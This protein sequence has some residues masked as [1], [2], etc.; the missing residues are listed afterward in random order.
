MYKLTPE[1]NN[2]EPIPGIP[3]RD[4]S[5]EEYA[6]VS[7]EYDAR[8]PDQPGSL[9]RWFHHVKDKPAEAGKEA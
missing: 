8:F 3:W 6:E 7:A 5:D 2:W 1:A 9:K 4:L